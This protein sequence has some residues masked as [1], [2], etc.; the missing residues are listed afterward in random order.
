MWTRW[1]KIGRDAEYLAILDPN[2]L[3]RR[4]NLGGCYLLTLREFLARQ[5]WFIGQ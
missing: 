4:E 5:R 1:R 3:A 2:A